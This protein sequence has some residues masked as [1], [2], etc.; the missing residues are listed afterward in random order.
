MFGALR[1]LAGRGQGFTWYVKFVHLL[2]W[3]VFDI[4]YRYVVMFGL[5]GTLLTSA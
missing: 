3:S 1:P 2:S 5:L 4:T